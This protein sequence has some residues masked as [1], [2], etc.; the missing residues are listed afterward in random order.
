MKPIEHVNIV[1]MGALGLLF[2]EPI[3]RNLGGGEPRY[4]MDPARKARHARDVYTI[5]GRTVQPAMITPAEVTKPADLVLVGVKYPALDE[6]MELMVSSVGPDTIL[7]SLMNGVDSEDRLAERFGKE[8]V[9]YSVSQEMDAQRYGSELVYTKAGQL[10][11]GVPDTA[12]EELK[13]V[14]TEKLDRVCAFFDAVELP[15]TR[16]ERI[17]Y[18]QWSKFM[19]N[20]GCNQVCMVYD[21]GYGPCMERG[22]EAFAMMTGAMREVCAVAQALGIPVGEKEVAQY[23]GILRTLDPAA[24][25]SMGQDRRQKNPSEVDMFAGVVIRYGERLGIPTPVNDFILRRVREIEA[26]YRP[27]VTA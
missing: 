4:V 21:A 15:H 3:R 27:G 23:L 19:L 26:A 5:N 14:L 2:G 17:I 25:P 7:V 1:G 10:Y 6:A 18:R 20:V 9:L 13:A 22:S 11:I 24:L 8:K 16:E 12:D